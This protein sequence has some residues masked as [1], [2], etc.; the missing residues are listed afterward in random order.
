M[1]AVV[2]ASGNEI[3]ASKVIVKVAKLGI[4]VVTFPLMNKMIDNNRKNLENG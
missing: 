3:P 1:I 4:K 2:S